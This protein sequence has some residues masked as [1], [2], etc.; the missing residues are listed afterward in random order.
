MKKLF[1]TIILVGA[2][3]AVFGFAGSAGAALTNDE[4]KTAA[5]G[6]G[7]SEQDIRDNLTSDPGYWES[8]YRSSYLPPTQTERQAQEERATASQQ[9]AEKEQKEKAASAEKPTVKG[10]IPGVGV[11]LG[12]PK[13]EFDMKECIAQAM[14]LVL[15]I[16]ARLLWLSGVLLNFT[17]QYTLNLNTLLEK[18]PIVDIG[19]KIIRDIANVVFIFIALWAGISITLGI[20]DNG[21]K[22][23]GL[24]AHMVLVALFIN[25]SLF[26]T[27]AIVDASNVAALHFYSLIGGGGA[28]DID[29]GLSSSFMQGLQIQTLWNSG[30]LQAGGS[31]SNPS[32]LQA[33]SQGV[34]ED[35]NWS[36]IILIGVFGSLVMVVAAWVFFAAAI[37]FI[38]RA[39]TLIF[40]MILSPLA[41]VGWILPGASGM[42]S[43]WWNKL[44][45]QALFAP[46]YL[47]L[48]YIVVAVINN[49]AYTTWLN[50]KNLSFAA[51]IT[52][53]SSPGIAALFFNFIILIGLM[54]GCLVIA[55]SLGAKGSE[56][57]MAGW[58][59]IKGGAMGVIGGMGRG[60]VRGKYL[61][62]GTGAA[63]GITQGAG[64]ILKMI[65]LKNFGGEALSNRGKAISRGGE[66]V[67]RKFLDAA[68]WDKSIGRSWIGN[69]AIGNF[70]RGQTTGRLMHAKFGG[71]TTVHEGYETDEQLRERRTEIEKIQ[72]AEQAS[73]RLEVARRQ[74]QQ[75]AKPDIA[76]LTDA[77]GNIDATKY[78]E[79]M[80]NYMQTFAPR[81][82]NYAAGIGGD[83]AFAEAQTLQANV[84]TDIP[85]RA[86]YAAGAAGDAAYI[87]ALQQYAKAFFEQPGA[88]FTDHTGVSTS[89]TGRDQTVAQTMADNRKT[90]ATAS[91]NNFKQAESDAYSA[92]NKIATSSFA[93][94]TEQQI[95]SLL[96]YANFAQ[97]KSFW[98]SKQ[99]TQDEKEHTVRVRWDDEYRGWKDFQ[100][101]V[102][103][104][105]QATR[106]YGDLARGDLARAGRFTL[107]QD[108]SPKDTDTEGYVLDGPGGR[109]VQDSNNND[110]KPPVAPTLPK[111]LEHW[112]RN[113]TTPAEFVL[114]SNVMPE[115]FKI[116]SLVR[117]MRWGQTHK[118][119]RNNEN[120]NYELRNS[121]SMT[122]DSKLDALMDDDKPYYLPENTATERQTALADPTRGAWKVAED[123]ARAAKI[124]AIAAGGARAANADQEAKMAF[125]NTF[126]QTFASQT[127]ADTLRMQRLLSWASGRAPDEVGNAR[128]K[129]RKSKQVAMVI[130]P[131]I[132]QTVANRD[133]EDGR[134]ILQHL[135][136][137]YRDEKNGNGIMTD[138]ARDTLKWL[139]S[140]PRAKNIPVPDDFRDEHDNVNT[141]LQNMF[142]EL[143]RQGIV[144][145]RN[146]KLE[147]DLERERRL[148]AAG[149]TP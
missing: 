86:N 81:R 121:L 52:G 99:W 14:N 98:E 44:W 61:T 18:L 117:T 60:I 140:D 28:N 15:W 90:K 83:R 139:V 5:T 32:V 129:Y 136:N 113:K 55:Q 149:V 77:N 126:N 65:G 23:W 130:T 47:A 147:F 80:R 41:F 35:L 37:M 115:I 36:S 142:R 128:S 46:L 132:F 100:N 94:M 64:K 68:E 96:K 50:G 91:E 109:R 26:I 89:L 112:L 13:V 93:D 85:D 72:S 124:T 29:G 102:D 143:K 88:T 22:A 63:G 79:A 12:G 66:S 57:G 76:S 20:G 106:E 34:A 17:L 146:V 108:G 19:W 70:V 73:G 3:S 9:R 6:A 141:Q 84:T 135:M 74:K 43:E 30:S 114:M 48:A 87:T 45:S 78:A 54:I 21:K 133:T 42:V 27:K 33:A 16:V 51:T 95:N 122:K 97:V 2:V 69:T 56:M 1:A 59:K 62:M 39:I 11:G 38:Y 137:A 107:N 118:E 58:E 101:V 125:D 25:F 148:R 92:V 103:K 144:Q 7:V 145:G 75:Y 116:P 71:G 10:C 110:I 111:H 127:P 138:T 82:E 40:L 53:T 134:A 105:E 104:F 120:M 49:P 67:R 8:Y 119:L 131:K 4:V 123:A 24:L 31:L